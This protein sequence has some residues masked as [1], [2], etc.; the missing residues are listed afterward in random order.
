MVIIALFELYERTFFGNIYNY[1]VRIFPL[2]LNILYKIQSNQSFFYEIIFNLEDIDPIYK[3]Q[4]TSSFL[5]A[6]EFQ[7][8]DFDVFYFEIIKVLKF[9]VIIV[10]KNKKD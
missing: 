3:F 2:D 8:I 4:K 9:D 1:C 6:Q 10:H 5:L 7:S